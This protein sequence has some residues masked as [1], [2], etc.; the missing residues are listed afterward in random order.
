MLAGRQAVGEGAQNLCYV[1]EGK[2]FKAALAERFLGVFNQLLGSIGDPVPTDC[3]CFAFT[4]QG[5][6]W[7]EILAQ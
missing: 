2:I 3:G 5:V 1:L 7:E 4:W 6:C